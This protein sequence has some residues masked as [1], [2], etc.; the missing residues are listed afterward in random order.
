VT[1][2]LFQVANDFGGNSTLVPPLPTFVQAFVYSGAASKNITVPTNGAF[3]VI[4]QNNTAAYYVKSGTGA[5]VP[6]ADD[7]TGVSAIARLAT[8]TVPSGVT[9]ISIATDAATVITIAW[10]KAA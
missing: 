8:F 7:T 9:S 1:T 6:A 10:Y 3:A 2:Q 5:A 4:S